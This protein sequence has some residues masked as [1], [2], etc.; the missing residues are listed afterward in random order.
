M[1]PEL[2]K[3]TMTSQDSDPSSL[4]ET[5]ARFRKA[6]R[7]VHATQALDEVL[8]RTISELYSV[9]NAEAASVALLDNKADEIILHAAGPVA[10]EIS[11]LRLPKEQ[12]IIGWVIAHRKS[13]LVNN[14]AT[15]ARFWPEIDSYSGFETRSILCAPLFSGD[16]VIGAVEVLNKQ[17]GEFTDGDLHFLEAFGAVA[18]SAIQNA[19]RFRLEQQR[20]READLIR[21]AVKVLSK[22]RDLTALLEVIL[23]QL[24]ELIPY[25]GATI[26]LVTGEGGLELAASRGFQ[27]PEHIARLVNQQ[28]IDANVQSMLDTDQALVI[29][30]LYETA[31]WQPGPELARFHAW[32]GAPLFVKGHLI[33]TLNVYHE[34]AHVYAPEE[35]RLVSSFMQQAAAPAIENNQ[36]YTATRE[37]TLARAAQARRMV[38]LYEASRALLSGLELD[39]EALRELL[40]R[41]TELVGVRYGLLDLQVRNS[42]P[43]LV[44]TVGFEIDARDFA[45][46]SSQI[47]DMLGS[48]RELLRDGNFEEPLVGN[49]HCLPANALNSLLGIAIHIRGRTYG[50]LLL[51][52]K[53]EGET[54]GQEDEALALA[55]ATNLASACENTSLYRD[56]QRRLQE[57]NALYEISHTVTEM[58]DSEDVYSHLAMQVAHLLDAERCVFLSFEKDRLTCLHPGYGIPPEDVSKLNFPVEVDSP[59]YEIIHTPDPLI[60]ND[61]LNDPDLA[62]QRGLLEQLQVQRLLSCRVALDEQPSALLIVAN[63]KG[64]E[65]F[66]EQDRHLVTIMIHQVNSVLQQALLQTQQ[67]EHALVQSALLQVSEAISSVT[68]LDELLH[69]VI[70]I[71][72]HLVGSSYSV[73]AVW[74]EQEGAFVPR[75][76]SGMAK[77]WADGPSKMYIRPAE[78][79]FVDE[80]TRT[81][82]PVLLVGPRDHETIP[83]AVQQLLLENSLIVPLVMQERVVGLIITTYAQEMAAPA[84]REIALLTGIAR[85]AAV[86]LENAQLYQDLQLHAGE[87]ER[88][89]SE[90]KEMDKQKSQ[91]VQ[92]VSHELRTPLTLIRGYL[93]L[94]MDEQLGS[95]NLRQREGLEAIAAKCRELGELIADIIAIQSISPDA[96][97]I[98]EFDFALLVN[99][100][101]QTLTAQRDGNSVR[102]QNNLQPNL[103][104][105][106]VDPDL[107]ERALLHLLDNA[108]KFSPHGGTVNI[109]AWPEQGWLYVQIED[110]GIGIPPE[111]IPYIFD[112][113]YQVDGSTTRRFGGTG[114]GLAIVKQI[115]RAHGGEIGVYSEPGRGSTF[116]FTLPLGE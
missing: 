11:G 100:A 107:I 46:L 55:L 63:K 74:E 36:L 53:R 76:R 33:G 112:H 97:E 39:K 71:S 62:N 79:D 92:N 90:L 84:E 20:R 41:V 83:A 9:L 78:V 101:W 73:L 34:Q 48:E 45:F 91:L 69:I 61:A 109:R 49:T 115:I 23:D 7:A 24:G 87:L 15:D 44:L 85:Q 51:A 70:Q 27:D 52:S 105:L 94:L 81:R 116:Y 66:T 59:L 5:L 16:Q 54:F 106:R 43:R 6:S 67:R 28:G 58:Q 65:P 110:E 93:E 42:D 89:Y 96:L 4:P 104:A 12:G 2:A 75:A 64:D 72:R 95:L 108:I 30:D 82:E 57:L 21:R 103:P 47:L 32:I 8:G 26:L 22:P 29:P 50:R 25:H 114:L 13:T 113:F 40:T 19:R 10:E 14:V 98:Q 3:A 1:P 38:S 68:D 88:A 111:S 60:S 99:V 37:A 80:I 102:L 56:T 17:H 77:A 35:A 86:A 31:G 18:A